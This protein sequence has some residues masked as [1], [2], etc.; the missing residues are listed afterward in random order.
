MKLLYVAS[1]G[2]ALLAVASVFI[3][4]LNLTT[5]A[6]VEN[7]LRGGDFEDK[8][9]LLEWELALADSKAEMKIDKTTVAIG[10]SSLFFKIDEQVGDKTRPRFQQRGHMIEK[11]KTYTL[12]ALLSG[13]T[14]WRHGRLR[15]AQARLYTMFLEMAT[16]V[17]LWAGQIGRKLGRHQGQMTLYH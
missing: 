8:E 3:L 2:L 1:K 6:E 14:L 12:S 7:L 4:A 10:K 16:T 11:G 13:M 9:D 5:L 17:S 15:K